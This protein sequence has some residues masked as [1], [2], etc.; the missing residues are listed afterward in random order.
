MY[1]SILEE[2]QEAGLV[3]NDAKWYMP[4]VLAK[5]QKLAANF[6]ALKAS[7]AWAAR[8]AKQAAAGEKPPAEA[9]G[10][11]KQKRRM[12]MMGSSKDGHAK[13]AGTMD[14]LAEL[15]NLLELKN[16]ILKA[17]ANGVNCDAHNELLDRFQH[18]EN[19]VDEIARTLQDLERGE[20]VAVDQQKAQNLIRWGR[21]VNVNKEQLDHFEDRWTAL[22]RKAPK[23]T[24]EEADAL[25]YDLKTCSLW[26]NPDEWKGYYNNK[27]VH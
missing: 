13:I 25:Y 20:N 14:R 23:A 11:K 26:R 19:V 8:A 16:T 15:R 24:R 10:D 1:E 4:D 18:A 22:K 7:P 17:E 5:F 21:E 2:A 9:E 12:T 3:G 27:L 6:D